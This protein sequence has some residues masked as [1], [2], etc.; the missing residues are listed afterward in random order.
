[1]IKLCLAVLLALVACA[2]GD[3]VLTGDTNKPD[4]SVYTPNEQVQLTF[5]I[6]GAA[7]GDW[8]N[9]ELNYLNEYDDLMGRTVQL[10]ICDENGEWTGTITP[11]SFIQNDTPK[12]GKKSGLG[13]ILVARDFQKR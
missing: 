2:V 11:D 13:S 3:Y 10:V 8:L 1:M 9:L 5:S 12:K 7:S 6:T 4:Y